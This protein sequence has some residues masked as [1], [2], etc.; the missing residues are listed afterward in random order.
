MKIV[1]I[2]TPVWNGGKPYVTVG[3]YHM[4]G[5]DGVS[6]QVMYK[7]K[8]GERLWPEDI[9]VMREEF[10]TLPTEKVRDINGRKV[11]LP[12]RYA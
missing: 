7:D 1:K 3:E 8:R 9:V 11:Y 5:Q 12:S 4:R 6:V 10:F 2:F